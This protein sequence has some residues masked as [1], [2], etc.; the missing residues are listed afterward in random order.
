MRIICYIVIP[1]QLSSCMKYESTYPKTQGASS[2]DQSSN[3]E[4]SDV[5]GEASTPET[6]ASETDTETQAGDDEVSTEPKTPGT[7]TS[8]SGGS[9]STPDKPKETPCMI[10]TSKKGQ[11]F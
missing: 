6:G 8:S 1:L 10:P 9:S 11:T 2:E 7:G 3:A 5:D 4:V